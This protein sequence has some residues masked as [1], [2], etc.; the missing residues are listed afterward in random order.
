MELLGLSAEDFAE[1]HEQVAEAFAYTAIPVQFLKH[2]AA[3]AVHSL[4]GEAADGEGDYPPFGTPIRAAVKFSPTDEV[5]TRFG[6]KSD[7]DVLI[8]IPRWM[9][10]DWESKNA[11]LAFVVDGS[12]RVQVQGDVYHI[13]KVVPDSVLPVGDGSA[14]E[15]IGLVVTAC[16]NKP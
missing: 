4:Y 15:Y 14:Q 7:A 8:H 3:E 6:L 5:L 12:M 13:E 10:L 2:D 16:T 9:I 11:P 1:I